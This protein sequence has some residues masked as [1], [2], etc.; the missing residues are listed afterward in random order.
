M[1]L[2]S[3]ATDA[4]P[5]IE[6]TLAQFK[7]ICA[8]P[9]FALSANHQA[10]LRELIERLYH[11]SDEFAAK[12]LAIEL[13]GR[14]TTIAKVEGRTVR[15]KLES[16]YNGDGRQDP[17]IVRLPARTFKPVIVKAAKEMSF[18]AGNF[19]LS[20]LDAVDTPSQ[21]SL[22]EA[23]HNV[24]EALA[25][26]PD[27]PRL[28]EI[29][30]YVHV[31]RALFGEDPRVEFEV[32]EYLVDRVIARHQGLGELWLAKAALYMSRWEW[33]QAGAAIGSA[34]KNRRAL[35]EVRSSPWNIVFL[36]AQRRFDE[37][38]KILD[39][40][41]RWASLSDSD[42]GALSA[43]V[44]ILAGDIV[45]A[46]EAIERAVSLGDRDWKTAIHLTPVLAVLLAEQGDFPN[47]IK[48]LDDAT[49]YPVT[50]IIGVAVPGLYALFYGKLG[51]VKRAR[52][53]YSEM[54][55]ERS[56]Y[57]FMVRV[58]RPCRRIPA[59]HLALAALGSGYEDE[60][61]GWLKIS[62]IVERDP[63]ALW[64]HILPF[65]KP[66]HSHVGFRSLV[67][68]TMKLKLLC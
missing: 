45:G 20:A 61:V 26:D 12:V 19:A 2:S 52:E 62:L 35:F 40:F 39:S 65:F 14:N 22:S 47:A 4:L 5:P 46:K 41:S 1:V 8:H 54:K 10:L 38:I 17:I 7:R 49:E 44:R 13:F 3:M 28:L 53:I 59:F 15:Q 55:A 30:A 37:A 18:H 29:K 36:A 67:T 6:E 11:G 68:V 32:A 23:I 64:M 63:L 16:Y 25:L 58:N 50:S 57:G 51:E 31:L 24:M 21:L 60:A 56:T 34:E 9:L 27:H 43:M 66:L 33:K 42:I 48:E